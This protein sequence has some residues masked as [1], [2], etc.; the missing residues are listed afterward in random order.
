MYLV[1]G[2]IPLNSSLLFSLPVLLVIERATIVGRESAQESSSKRTHPPWVWVF[3]SPKER[4]ERK[5]DDFLADVFVVGQ[6][7][8]FVRHRGVS[9]NSMHLNRFERKDQAC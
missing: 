7:Q 9:V 1:A 5:R 4:A 3:T 2:V 8:S 6:A